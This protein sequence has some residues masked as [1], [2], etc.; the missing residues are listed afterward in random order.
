MNRL[1]SISVSRRCSLLQRSFATYAESQQRIVSKWYR[2]FQKPSLL[3][4]WSFGLVGHPGLPPPSGL[5]PEFSHDL[6]TSLSIKTAA[7]ESYRWAYVTED[8]SVFMLGR[9]SHGE[10]GLGANVTQ[11]LKPTKI[12]GLPPVKQIICKKYYT[13][14]VTDSGDVYTWGR[15]GKYAPLGHG[16]LE[17]SYTPRKVES[18]SK[19]KQIACAPSHMIALTENGEMFSWGNPRYGVLG[20]G[21]VRPYADKP[22]LIPSAVDIDKIACNALVSA[23]I[24][25]RGILYTWGVATKDQDPKA[26]IQKPRD[27]ETVKIPKLDLVPKVVVKM[28]HKPVLSVN[29]GPNFVTCVTK[30]H[31]VYYFAAGRIPKKMFVPT[32]SRVDESSRNSGVEHIETILIDQEA[33]ALDSFGHLLFVH[34]FK[35][36]HIT[37]RAFGFGPFQPFP[38]QPDVINPFGR[39]KEFFWSP[40]NLIIRAEMTV[41]EARLAKI[42]PPVEAL[43]AQLNFDYKP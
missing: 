40:H 41:H 13:A 26:V 27:Q 8:G 29:V 35:K 39:A 5:T 19:V 12:E 18:V 42:T 33:I 15:G 22:M 36:G 10:L 2:F 24:T 3:S 43:Q 34:R 31:E 23:A 4:R 7:I 32:S 11:C 1:L 9:G 16:N 25:R 30:A 14:A 37:D 21:V 6:D 28:Q 20:I 17:T 38:D